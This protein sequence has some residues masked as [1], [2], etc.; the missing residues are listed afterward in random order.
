MAFI[1]DMMSE[2][3]A[4]LAWKF[5]VS[6]DSCDNPA[7]YENYIRLCAIG[8]QISGMGVTHLMLDVDEKGNV[9]AIAG[10]ITLRAT[11]L[12]DA[13]EDGKK[14]VNP[15]LEIAELAV[16]KEYE[17]KG[18]G[19]QLVKLAIAVAD[20]LRRE[21]LGIKNIVLC[22]DPKAV[23]FYKKRKFDMIEDWYEALHDGWND[24]CEAMYISL[25]ELDKIKWDT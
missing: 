4:G 14:M 5:H 2:K 23:G 1:P 3:Y 7:H 20:E 11:S 22:A 8:Q 16:D 6:P 21:Y 17:R 13:N 18:I 15:S 9:L 24:H 12:I 19:T 25:L 10:Y